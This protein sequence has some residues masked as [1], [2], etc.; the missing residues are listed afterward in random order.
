MSRWNNYLEGLLDLKD[1]L[2]FLRSDKIGFRYSHH[3]GRLNVS[4]A[5]LT[6]L[7]NLVEHLSESH[8]IFAPFVEAVN[9]DY[10][11]P[12][13]SPATFE[14]SLYSELHATIEEQVRLESAPDE[15]CADGSPS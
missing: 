6:L 15:R 4:P 12:E 13:T 9:K 7:R 14:Q 3:P 11:S 1:T 2:E 10:L 5:R 8:Q